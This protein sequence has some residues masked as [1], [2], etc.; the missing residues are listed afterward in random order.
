MD[1]GAAL[2]ERLTRLEQLC[3]GRPAHVLFNDYI[4]T[5]VAEGLLDPT[6][7][8]V[9]S[10]VYHRSHYGTIDLEEEPMIEAVRGLDDLIV[11]FAALDDVRRS[12]VANTVARRLE[13]RGP[14]EYS[15]DSFVLPNKMTAPVGN[16]TL[17]EAAN[18]A[19]RRVSGPPPADNARPAESAARFDSRKGVRAEVAV[20]AAMAFFAAGYFVR[21]LIAPAAKSESVVVGVVSPKAGDHRSDSLTARTVWTDERAFVSNLQER[22]MLEAEHGQDQ[23]AERGYRLLLSYRSE[24]PFV[25]KSLAWLYLTTRDP[26]LRN[27]KL[28]R[29]L[30]LQALASNRSPEILNAAAEGE[31]Q[32]GYLDEALRLQREAV[33]KLPVGGGMLT[34]RLRRPF[35]QQLVKFQIAHQAARKAQAASQT[36]S[37]AFPASTGAG[38]TKAASSIRPPVQAVRPEAR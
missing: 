17:G 5:F 19:V 15:A 26:T 1:R 36:A 8:D 9:V 7:A 32:A 3:V 23:R 14:L 6:V 20:V 16:L 18:S 11:R 33:E 13:L 34:Q 37:P 28:G 12:D 38:S 29:E 30:G 24:D 22:T 2:T 27:S 25:L 10:D 21:D 4:K 35:E 31:Y